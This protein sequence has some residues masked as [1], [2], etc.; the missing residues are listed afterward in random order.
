MVK[1]VKIA[2]GMKIPRGKQSKLKKK[3]GGS[4][5]GEY[6]EVS[7]GS[8]C[9]PSGGA[10]KGSYPVNTRKRAIAAKSYS[11]NAPNPAGIKA[12]VNRKWPS[13]SKKAKKK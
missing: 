12:C 9:G 11:R 13:L 10:P 4:N 5:V 6:K 3:P 1:K 7:K 2:K 8:F